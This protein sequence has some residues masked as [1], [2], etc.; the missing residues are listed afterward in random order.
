MFIQFLS[1]E[2]LLSL[3]QYCAI[4]WDSWGV[5]YLLH[6]SR[7]SA[8]TYRGKSNLCD[9]LMYK[10]I[11][12]LSFIQI[13]LFIRDRVPNFDTPSE[14]FAFIYT[15]IREAYI[16]YPFLRKIYKRIWMKSVT[17]KVYEEDEF[18]KLKNIKDNE[19]WS[20]FVQ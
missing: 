17:E 15:L 3:V 4:I 11:L 9:I 6:A 16:L 14:T 18:E 20:N 2:R 10:I 12:L 13:R 7:S 1:R 19:L 5:T 8:Q